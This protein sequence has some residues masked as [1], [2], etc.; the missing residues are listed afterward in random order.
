MESK[1]EK[2]K[3]RLSHLAWKRCKFSAFPAAA[4]ITAGSNCLQARAGTS[5]NGMS[6]SEI[7]V[8]WANSSWLAAGRWSKLAVEELV[9]LLRL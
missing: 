1:V 3:E 8:D 2:A 6:S 4:A 9:L 7:S 5:Q